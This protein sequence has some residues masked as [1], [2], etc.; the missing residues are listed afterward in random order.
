MKC[1][2]GCCKVSD[3][4]SDC[5]DQIPGIAKLNKELSF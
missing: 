5:I 1:C 2:Y 3:K 4:V